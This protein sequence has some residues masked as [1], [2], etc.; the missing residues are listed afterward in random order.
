MP[1]PLDPV[2]LTLAR[3]EMQRGVEE[4]PG[5]ASNPRI[6]EYHAATSLRASDDATS[7]CSA[8]V[9][10]LMRE[11]RIPGSG[12]AVARSWLGWGV[13]EALPRLGAIVILKRGTQAWQAHVALLLA[14]K[15]DRLTVLGGNQSD[16]VSIAS[17]PATRL[18]GYRWP[19]GDALMDAGLDAAGR[20]V[21]RS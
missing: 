6:I 1:A 4:L 16:R 2:W 13:A 7:W 18:L 3:A 21:V 20:R 8:F 17:F 19:T 15:G 14:V 9:N 10:W 11:C 5:R 12:S